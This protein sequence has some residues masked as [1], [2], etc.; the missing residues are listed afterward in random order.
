MRKWTRVAAYG[1]ILD[2][3]QIL[4]CRLS[5][6][7]KDVGKWTLPGGGLNFG[8]SPEAGVLREIWEETGLE[9]RL[10][11]HAGIDSKLCEFHDGLMHAIR[12]LYWAEP[13][14]GELSVELNGSTDACQWF[15]EAEA[16][17]LPL[18]DLAE[19]GVQM[20]FARQD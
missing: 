11:G 17:R 18:V 3:G 9:A 8:E 20:A 10:I 12:I 4:L 14:Q 6:Q 19:L 13:V 2:Q 1:L 15:T 16:L 5:S 7:E